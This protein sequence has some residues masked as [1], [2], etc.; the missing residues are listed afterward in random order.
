MTK[1]ISFARATV[2]RVCST[3]VAPR[4]NHVQTTLGGSVIQW[5]GSTCQIG[6]YESLGG[7]SAEGFAMRCDASCGSL[8]GLRPNPLETREKVRRPRDQQARKDR[9]CGRNDH[10]DRSSRDRSERQL[11]QWERLILRVV[12]A[13]PLG[14]DL[15][16]VG[17]SIGRLPNHDTQIVTA[18]F[19]SHRKPFGSC[20][21]FSSSSQT[22]STRGT[23]AVAPAAQKSCAHTN[24]FASLPT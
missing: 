9:G 24:K 1:Q 5:R 18:R 7:A 11:R 23:C 6:V 17:V 14:H 8:R 20:E 16:E 12:L 13:V 10:E 4:S 21:A 3:S 19:E 2:L 15:D 22:P